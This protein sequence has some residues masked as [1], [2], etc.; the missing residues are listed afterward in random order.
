MLDRMGIA[1]ARD[2]L[3]PPLI[4]GNLL[5]VDVPVED[6][7]ESL[8]DLLDGNGAADDGIG[9]ARGQRRGP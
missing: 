5:V 6:A 7:R 2:N 8:D 4:V 3:A 1:A 9:G